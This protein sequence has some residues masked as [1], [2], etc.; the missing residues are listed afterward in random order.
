M[1]IAL[2]YSWLEL[3]FTFKKYAQFIKIFFSDIFFQQLLAGLQ[4]VIFPKNTFQIS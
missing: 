2:S 1:S 3:L 4:A